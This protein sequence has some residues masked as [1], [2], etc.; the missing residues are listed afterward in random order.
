MISLPFIFI[1]SECAHCYGSV[2]VC[3]QQAQFAA[4]E[5]IGR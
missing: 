2:S 1:I 3:Y 5:F 4:H